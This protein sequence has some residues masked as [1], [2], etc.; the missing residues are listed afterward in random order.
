MSRQKQQPQNIKNARTPAEAEIEYRIAAHQ[1]QQR[2]A[3]A[4]AWQ[5]AQEQG[6]ASARLLP[7]ALGRL[8]SIN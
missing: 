6:A 8:I 4:A 1:L 3:E 2:M 5:Q 7:S